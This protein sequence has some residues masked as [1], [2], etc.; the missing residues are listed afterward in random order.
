[1]DPDPGVP[2]TY[3]YDGSGSATLFTPS[4]PKQ[5]YW[6]IVKRKNPRKPDSPV[7]DVLQGSV[8]I[9]GLVLG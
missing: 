1:M 3:G 9:I 5:V 7:E 8:H 6:Q 4:V 2:K